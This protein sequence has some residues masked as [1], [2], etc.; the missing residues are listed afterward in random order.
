MT[1]KAI[2]HW[3]LGKRKDRLAGV[4]I[5]PYHNY[6]SSKYDALGIPYQLSDLESPTDEYMQQIRGT[7]EQYGL[8]VQIGG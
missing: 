7:L 6:G 8:K 4:H 2:S 3:F 5:L 1:K